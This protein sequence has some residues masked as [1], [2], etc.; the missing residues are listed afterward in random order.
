MK[1]EH[2]SNSQQG[3]PSLSKLLDPPPITTETLQY[4]LDT[5]NI[6]KAGGQRSSLTRCAQKYGGFR[7]MLLSEEPDAEAIETSKQGLLRELG[8][9]ELELTKLILYQQ[10]LERQV[11]RN[12]EMQANREQ[13]LHQFKAGVAESSAR[14]NK[15]KETENCKIEYEALARLINEKHPTS[16]EEL[17]KQIDEMKDETKQLDKEIVE[18]DQVL[19]VREA[20]YQLLLQYM[21]DLKR[22]LKEDEEDE[23][24]GEARKG[25]KPVPMDVDDSLYADL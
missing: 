23:N 24:D 15:S 20:Q 10:S 8:L 18:K 13:E 6:G 16:R 21:L 3:D 14:A 9:F 5:G 7:S 12:Q 25:D 4:R 1:P 17:Q 22:S 19:K 2:T 11:K